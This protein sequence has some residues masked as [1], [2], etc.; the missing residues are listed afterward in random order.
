MP[1]LQIRLFAIFYLL[2]SCYV[3]AVAQDVD[4]PIEFRRDVLPI[5]SENCFAC[6]GFD[7]QARQAD[8]RLDTESGATRVAES[9]LIAVVPGKPHESELVQRISSGDPDLR[10][11]PPETEKSLSAATQVVKFLKC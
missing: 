2:N 3:A 8:L 4:R 1:S 9:G 5:L 10:M 7:E 11:P 6:H